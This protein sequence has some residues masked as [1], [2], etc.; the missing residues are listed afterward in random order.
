MIKASKALGELNPF[1]KFNVPFAFHVDLA[2]E[3]NGQECAI[4]SANVCPLFL[5]CL[6]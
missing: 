3:K 1:K 4:F 5:L 6:M 2:I